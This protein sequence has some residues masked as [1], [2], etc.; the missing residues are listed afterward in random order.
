MKALY[1]V[2]NERNIEPLKR[3]IPPFN[4]NQRKDAVNDERGLL[5][6][7]Q[8][9]NLYYNIENGF[10]TKEE[11]RKRILDFGLINLEP[12]LLELGKPYQYYQNHTI[13]CIELN[14]NE[15]AK[16]DY[17]AYSID[18]KWQKVEIL[19]LEQ[20]HKQQD[21]VSN[22]KVGIKVKERLPECVLYHMK[23]LHNN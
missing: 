18:G 21:K 4:E 10:I 8:L 3:T 23:S 7:W 19:E 2:N 12:Q 9:F 15:I 6:T 20:D 22:G 17:L 5:Y 1:I 16:N 13:A 11:A 14:N